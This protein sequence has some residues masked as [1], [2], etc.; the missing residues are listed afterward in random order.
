MSRRAQLAGGGALDGAVG[1]W[2]A[3]HA[4]CEIGGARRGP[5]RADGAKLAGASAHVLA[6]GAQGHA[7]GARAV[8]VQAPIAG[9]ALQVRALQ[10]G[11]LAVAN[12]AAH[13]PGRAHAP[14]DARLARA[15]ASFAG[16]ARVEQG[17]S[18]ATAQV[19]S[20]ED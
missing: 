2:L 10:E 7:R 4:V 15:G 9:L 17:P 8:P 14:L 16:T 3:G 1:V 13:G 18:A 11:L 5:E 12:A 20:D 6:G 19:D